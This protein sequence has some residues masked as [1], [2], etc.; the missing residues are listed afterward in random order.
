MEGL[1]V[2]AEASTSA[3]NAAVIVDEMI[4]ALRE[5]VLAAEHL[6]PGWT[7]SP[8]QKLDAAAQDTA[9]GVVAYRPPNLDEAAARFLWARATQHMQTIAAEV[10]NNGQGAGAAKAPEAWALE[11][12]HIAMRGPA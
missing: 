12:E 2:V 1:A 5:A 8:A 3:D 11:A 6:P 4:P 9:A 10:R 7:R